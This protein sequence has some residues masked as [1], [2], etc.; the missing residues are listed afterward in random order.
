[1]NFY[2]QFRETW[3]HIRIGITELMSSLFGN[4]FLKLRITVLTKRKM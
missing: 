4:K 2:K 1:M 3:S